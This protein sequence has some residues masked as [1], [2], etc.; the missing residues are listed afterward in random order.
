MKNNI[1]SD[2]KT[3]FSNLESDMANNHIRYIHSYHDKKANAFHH[4][5][6]GNEDTFTK[7]IYH[8]KSGTLSVCKISNQERLNTV[9]RWAHGSGTFVC[10]NEKKDMLTIFNALKKLIQKGGD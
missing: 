6:Y 2:S 3:L 4:I 10:F 1:I 5:F 8:V 7:V 9:V